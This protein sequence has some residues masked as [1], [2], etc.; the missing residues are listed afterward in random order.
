M[1]RNKRKEEE[2]AG[3]EENKFTNNRK[4]NKRTRTPGKGNYDNNGYKRKKQE[5]IFNVADEKEVRLKDI[6]P[7]DQISWPSDSEELAEWSPP[8]SEDGKR[9]KFMIQVAEQAPSQ[10]IVKQE[11]PA[12]PPQMLQQMPTIEIKEH[13]E[14]KIFLNPFLK[15]NYFLLTNSENFSSI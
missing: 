6:I 1:K 12:Q 13:I 14:S 3:I 11:I 9:P 15:S 8:C 2:E 4:D 10:V 7:A 5:P